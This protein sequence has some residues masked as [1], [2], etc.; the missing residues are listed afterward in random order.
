MNYIDW[1]HKWEGSTFVDGENSKYG[2]TLPTFNVWKQRFN[3]TPYTLDEIKNLS[4]NEAGDMVDR[5]L[6]YHNYDKRNPASYHIFDFIWGS[7]RATKLIFDLANEKYKELLSGG[8]SGSEPTIS[9]FLAK[10]YEL[11]KNKQADFIN[12]LTKIRYDYLKSLNKPEYEKGWFNRV[13]D[14]NKNFPI[15][16]ITQEIE[17]D[18]ESSNVLFFIGFILLA[19]FFFFKSWRK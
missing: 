5:A 10:F 3:E 2:W 7:G 19:V 9:K 8:Y 13:D 14:L 1:L 15:A 17:K 6:H 16:S 11:P 4:K 18:K 12:E